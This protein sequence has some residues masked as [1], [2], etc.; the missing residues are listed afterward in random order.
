MAA[1]APV[2]AIEGRSV[3]QVR[4]VCGFDGADLSQLPLSWRLALE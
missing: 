3:A 1:T 2:A 4:R